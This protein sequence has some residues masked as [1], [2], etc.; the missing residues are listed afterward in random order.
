MVVEVVFK[1]T[2]PA[3]S[4]S[5]NQSPIISGIAEIS[6]KYQMDFLYWNGQQYI[7]DFSFFNTAGD[8]YD[9]DAEFFDIDLYLILSD[10]DLTKK[11][12]KIRYKDKYLLEIIGG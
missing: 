11:Y 9:I 3:T 12:Q 10:V 2:P 6:N 5:I 4:P 8:S 1:V 7:D